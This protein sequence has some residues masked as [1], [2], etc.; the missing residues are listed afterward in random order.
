MPDRI[1]QTRGNLNNL[2][3]A[4]KMPKK[5]C[6]PLLNIKEVNIEINSEAKIFTFEVDK[7]KKV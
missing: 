3:K 7:S 6:L 4:P 1:Y 2:K 5:R